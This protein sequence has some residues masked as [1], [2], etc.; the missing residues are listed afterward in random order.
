MT[1]VKLTSAI[2]SIGAAIIF[3]T[4]VQAGEIILSTPSYD[5][6]D[7]Y[8]F[9]TT[10]PPTGSTTIGTY[11]FTPFTTVELASITGITIS[12]TFGNGDSNTT[13]L[14]DYYLGI[15]GG[16][17]TE[18]EVAACDDPLA[19]CYSGQ[20]GPYTWNTTLTPTEI[21]E[22]APALEA[23]SIDFTYTW[24]SGAPPIPDF[25]SLTGFD[26]Q[27]VYAGATTLDI[28]TTPEPST[29]L[30]CLSGLAGVVLLRRFR[31]V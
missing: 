10:T 6:P 27:Y 20:E 31:K 8:D 22:L 1:K 16:D 24:D 11:T 29:V 25:F 17:E 18:V 7:G 5:S 13:A 21:T 23:G 3:I 26:D 28:M 9:V 2:L 19:N 30:F 14:S 15:P 12:G 4:P